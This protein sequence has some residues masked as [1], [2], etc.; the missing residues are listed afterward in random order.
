MLNRTYRMLSANRDGLNLGTESVARAKGVNMAGS[1]PRLRHVHPLQGL[2]AVRAG[3]F[4][5]FG[6]PSITE[7]DPTTERPGSPTATPRLTPS[8]RI[9]ARVVVAEA[10]PVVR[11]VVQDDCA[12]RPEVRT[13][14]P[15]PAGGP[16]TPRA[17]KRKAAAS[18]PRRARTA[19]RTRMAESTIA[20]P[21]GAATSAASGG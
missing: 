12:S 21:A 7:G 8:R 6:W 1:S 2:D 20:T 16:Q 3:M 10:P 14:S 9:A 13:Q 11:P 18:C 17:G 5:P 19:D 15:S 4:R